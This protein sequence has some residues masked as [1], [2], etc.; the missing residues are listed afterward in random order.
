MD[1]PTALIKD[2]IGNY[3]DRRRDRRYPC[4]LQ[5]SIETAQETMACEITS[6]SSGGLSARCARQLEK[7]EEVAIRLVGADR[8]LKCQVQWASKAD[9][10]ARLS[11]SE[12]DSEGWLTEELKKLG[13]QARESRQRRVGVR[14][15][16]RIPARLSWPNGGEREALIL[17]LGITGARVECAEDPL[18]EDLVIRFGPVEQLPEVAANAKLISTHDAQAMQHGIVFT[19]FAS[20]GDKVLLDYVNHLFRSQ[21]SP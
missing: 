17:D 10:I 1:K 3:A 2:L 5:G 7:G 15:K 8:P 18:P 19:S 6:L 4:Q 16:C 21:R 14:V 12:H 13:D 20:G 11:L 9:L